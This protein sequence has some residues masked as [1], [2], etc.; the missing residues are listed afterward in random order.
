M[1]GPPAQRVPA[2]GARNVLSCVPRTPCM[3]TW[4][5]VCRVTT[6]RAA[7]S[8]VVAGPARHLPCPPLFLQVAVSLLPPLPSAPDIWRLAASVNGRSLS[9]GTTTTPTGIK[10]S[11]SDGG[12]G[13][14]GTAKVEAG[15]ITISMIQK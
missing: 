11:F 5:A 10:V 8:A 13:K 7:A 3:Q 2:A 1:L 12:I 4:A 6:A 14:F 9:A 15:F